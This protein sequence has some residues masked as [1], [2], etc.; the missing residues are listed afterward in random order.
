MGV[1]PTKDTKCPPTG[2]KPA[3]PTGTSLPPRIYSSIIE[4]SSGKYQRFDAMLI[5]Y[6]QRWLDLNQI[7]NS[8]LFHGYYNRAFMFDSL[9]DRL[10]GFKD[11]Q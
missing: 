1:E 9:F 7:R 10:Y 4:W 8:C 5:V 6:R 2:L 11:F 3:K